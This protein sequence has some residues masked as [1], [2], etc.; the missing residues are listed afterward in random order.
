[1]SVFTR[2]I[3]RLK[4]RDYRVE[5]IIDPDFN[6]ESQFLRIEGRKIRIVVRSTIAAKAYLEEALERVQNSK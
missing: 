4:H 2:T 5:L 6:S 3:T 1:M